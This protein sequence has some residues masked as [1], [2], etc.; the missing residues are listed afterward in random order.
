[1]SDV[2]IQ[3]VVRA[4]NSVIQCSYLYKGDHCVF[5]A[6]KAGHMFIALPLLLLNDLNAV[7][8]VLWGVQ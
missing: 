3:F 6:I 1:M 5:V 7:G 4:H 8:K 2:C